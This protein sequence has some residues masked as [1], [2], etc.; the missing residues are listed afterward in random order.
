MPEFKA[1]ILDLD[2]VITRTAD[3]HARA[4][5]RM[6]DDYLSKHTEGQ[7][8]FDIQ[9]DYRE[10]IDGKPRYD[11]VRSFL[12]SR[13]LVLPNGAPDDPPGKETVCG[14]GNR[15]NE[16][17]HALLDREGVETFDDA[18]EQLAAWQ[19]QKVKTA[20]VSSSRNCV[21]VLRAAGLEHLFDAKVD[22]VDADELGLEGKPAP[23]IFIEAAARLGVEPAE[24]VVVEDAI[25]GVRAGR[26]GNFGMIV[27]VV[28]GQN[29][30]ALHAHGADAV[31]RDLR[32][33]EDLIHG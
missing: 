7:P 11:G 4:W 31:V 13:D 22:G 19:H 30:T 25:A 3:L 6:F 9:D 10:Y 33:I 1:V 27:G 2:G 24:A 16:I 21:P 26:A 8:P 14:L 18:V 28:R 5:K 29:D 15:K 12:K 32:R 20:V 23:D 17:F